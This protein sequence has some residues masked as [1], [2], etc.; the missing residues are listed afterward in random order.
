MLTIKF[1]YMENSKNKSFFS[2][3]S[4]FRSNVVNVSPEPIE[5]SIESS[6]ETPI[7]KKAFEIDSKKN[8][9]V[10]AKRSPTSVIS[11]SPEVVVSSEVI[12]VEN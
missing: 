1:F 5:S 7:E 6:I 2:C 11:I 10:S 3:F 9:K 8:N 4:C 12:I